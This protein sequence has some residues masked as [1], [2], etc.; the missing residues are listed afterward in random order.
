MGG[1]H[2]AELSIR[3][4]ALRKDPVSHR[5]SAHLRAN[6]GYN[7]GDISAQDGRENERGEALILAAA[8]L[9][10]EGVDGGGR[11]A[12][13]QLPGGR[14]RIGGVSPL[15]NLGGGRIFPG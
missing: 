2:R 7:T 14:D 13:E 15:E 10:I 11:Q 1:C 5:K 8:L 4:P 12:D 3:C 9:Y 6:L